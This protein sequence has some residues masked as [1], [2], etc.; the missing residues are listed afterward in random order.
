[1]FLV[2]FTWFLVLFSGFYPF[3]CT[4]SCFVHQPP[5]LCGFVTW[6]LDDFIGFFIVFS[7]SSC[8]T[9]VSQSRC[10]KKGAIM[11]APFVTA[12]TWINIFQEPVLGLTSLGLVG[13]CHFF[14]GFWNLFPKVFVNFWWFS[15]GFEGVLW[16]FRRFFGDCLPLERLRWWFLASLGHSKVGRALFGL[17]FF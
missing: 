11:K 3:R 9:L 1:M 16:C 8:V 14:W 10:S 6:C 2:G 15:M 4:S 13:L 17:I 5:S 7:R 12:G